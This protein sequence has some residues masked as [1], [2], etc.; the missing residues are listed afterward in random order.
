MSGLP[1]LSVLDLATVADGSTPADAL[2]NSL[3]LS[4]HAE[5][6]GFHR[7]WV[8]EHHNMPGIASSA[9]A[10]LIAEIASAT[11]TMRVGSGGVMLPNHAP[12]VVAE[13]FG[14]LDALHPGRIDLGIGRAPGTDGVTAMALRRDA[15]PLSDDD[16]PQALG[17]LVSFF[18]GKF[19]DGHPYGSITAVPGA[20]NLP[21]IWLLGSSGYS[22]QVAGMLGWPFSFAH[23]FMARNTLP[24]LE[25]YRN[26]F[27]P[28]PRLQKPEAMVAVAV[29][30]ADDDETARYLSRPARLSMA[31]L[32][33]GNPTRMPSNEEAE[34][35]EF[36]PADEA[37]I[38]EMS[39]S[40]I[41][42]SPETVRRRLEELAEST[43]ADEF[44]ITT[45]VY[46]H[47][48][49]MRSYELV[50]ELVATPAANVPR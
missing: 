26:T 24:A 18:E 49:R 50:A 7:Y 29:I 30:C 43:E 35:Y 32:R 44:M 11:E 38:A 19:P 9:P 45:M 25:L 5:R 28:S 37:K 36:S 31:R 1:K 23:H 47:A 34:A 20:G 2:R 14:M 42:G 6:L 48:D 46:D 3:E 13:Q 16:F 15:N 10:V 17:E 39:G 8:A 21:E 40:A 12:L 4:Q 41:V 33:S 27:K 22:A